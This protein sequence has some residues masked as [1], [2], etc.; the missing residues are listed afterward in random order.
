ML[1]AFAAAVRDFDFDAVKARV[2]STAIPSR[3]RPKRLVLPPMASWWLFF[4][5][6]PALKGCTA[7]SGQRGYLNRGTAP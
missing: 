1:Q 3:A 7:L 2:A 5:K 6:L 4:P